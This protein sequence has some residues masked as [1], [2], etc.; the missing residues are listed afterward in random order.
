MKDKSC[1]N[2]ISPFFCSPK[3]V[4]NWL[5]DLE[6][7]TNKHYTDSKDSGSVQTMSDKNT[8]H[9]GAFLKEFIL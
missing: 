5:N 3:D 2:Q 7:N 1:P 4:L 9:K 8:L 6:Y